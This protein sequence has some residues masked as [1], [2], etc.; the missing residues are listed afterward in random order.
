MNAFARVSGQPPEQET[1]AEVV[2]CIHQNSKL[3]ALRDGLQSVAHDRGTT[4]GVLST[5]GFPHLY[6]I[7][8][9]VSQLTQIRCV[10]GLEGF[11]LHSLTLSRGVRMAGTRRGPRLPC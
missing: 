1:R 11:N 9:N 10:V 8:G 4:P 5:D 3:L 2:S 7:H 6:L